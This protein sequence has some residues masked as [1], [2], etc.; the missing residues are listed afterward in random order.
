MA[1]IV[2]KQDKSNQLLLLPPEIGSL[3]PENHIVRV[4]DEVINQIKLAPLFDTYKGGGTSS[5]S[6]RV[7]LKV[8]T[9]AYTQG[10]YTTRKIEKALRESVNFMWISGMST[11]DH[12]TIHNFRAKRMKEAVENIF[13]SVLDVLIQRGV[14]IN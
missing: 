2:F 8:L 10:I 13:S 11:P 12:G 9:Y 6:P 1:K 3:I 5:Y 4:V 14:Y 7:M